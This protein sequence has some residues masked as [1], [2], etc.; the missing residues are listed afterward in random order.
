MS[1]QDDLIGIV[2]AGILLTT[3]LIASVA[4]NPSPS[5]HKA[6]AAAGAFSDLR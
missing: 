2:I 1:D 4:F 6:Q 5:G 3:I